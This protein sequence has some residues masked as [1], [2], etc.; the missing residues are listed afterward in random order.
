MI[1]D[2]PPKVLKPQ[3]QPQFKPDPKDVRAFRKRVDR[4]KL[5]IAVTVLDESSTVLPELRQQLSE[6][7]EATRLARDA[8]ER[9]NTVALNELLDHGYEFMNGKKIAGKEFE[10]W[11]DANAA[12]RSFKWQIAREAMFAEYE[13]DA[14]LQLHRLEKRGKLKRIA[15][16]I[17]RERNILE[18]ALKPKS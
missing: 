10:P 15:Q 2:R 8:K 18:K 16:G 3:R 14:M 7:L 9:A 17:I 4:I 5:L 12:V 13:Q 1:R 11:T 6:Q